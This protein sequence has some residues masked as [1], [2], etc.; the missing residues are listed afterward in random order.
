MSALNDLER[1]LKAA[2]SA[3]HQERVGLGAPAELLAPAPARRRP[4]RRLAVAG[5][6][7]ALTAAIT[8]GGLALEQDGDGPA[9]L[10]G[11]VSAMADRITARKGV[12]H[13]VTG[14]TRVRTGDGPWQDFG[15]AH[16]EAWVDLDRGGWRDRVIDDGVVTGD[17]LQRPDGT[18]LTQRK[19]GAPRVNT[20]TRG[21]PQDQ[22]LP[23]QAW[24]GFVGARLR[25]IGDLEETGRTTVDGRPAVVVRQQDV[26]DLDY[27][28]VIDEESG[29][30]RKIVQRIPLRDGT[31]Y[32]TR[33]DVA[34][35]EIVPDSPALR[36]RLSTLDRLGDRA[37]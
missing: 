11:A 2:N 15:T 20:A 26:G 33:T 31:V 22:L 24:G 36:Q 6:L 30:L 32:E 16:D 3:L 23:R 10:P 7:A 5:T 34:R 8:V 19:A 17:G 25:G 37:D 13:V 18:E 35:W 27:R 28:F 12:L 4:R 1:Q 29:A 9:G 21:L 14:D